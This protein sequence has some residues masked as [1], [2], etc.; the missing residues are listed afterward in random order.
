MNYDLIKRLFINMS[1]LLDLFCNF[2]Q[3]ACFKHQTSSFVEFCITL[4]AFFPK[5]KLHLPTFS[6]PEVRRF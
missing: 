5:K 1:S 2:Y 3:S 6:A 4:D